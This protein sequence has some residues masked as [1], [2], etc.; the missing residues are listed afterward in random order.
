MQTVY[1]AGGCLWSVQY[2]MNTIPGVVATEAG[3][4]NGKTDSLSSPYDGYV[5]CV[6]VTYDEQQ[7]S[8][9]E[10]TG[11]LFEIIDPYSINHQGMDYGEK[12]R[13]GVY[14]TDEN[15]LKEARQFI[16]ERPDADL[17]QIEVR[18]L[19]QYVPSAPEHQNH[20]ER[21]PEDH[22]LCSIPWSLLK[23]YRHNQAVR[24]PD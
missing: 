10:L 14:S 1:L 21:Y 5:E 8:A 9:R 24:Q 3:R 15:V 7:I 18:P 6:K 11:H 17:I 20:L 12:Y 23:K 13:T 2:F 19:T 16:A 22:Y 4:A